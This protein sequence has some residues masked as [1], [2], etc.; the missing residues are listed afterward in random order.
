MLKQLT[1]FILFR[2]GMGVLFTLGLKVI[3]HFSNQEYF[4][5]GL[6]EEFVIYAFTF[7]IVSLLSKESPLRNKNKEFG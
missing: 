7:I 2:A 1:T 4:F 5:D 6:L 3:Q